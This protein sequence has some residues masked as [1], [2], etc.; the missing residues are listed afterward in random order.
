LVEPLKR[1]RVFGSA[2]VASDEVAA[3]D[4]AA[5]H[6]SSKL[7]TSG[8]FWQR[9]W[10]LLIALAGCIIV[11]TSL[12][13]IG[14]DGYY[15]E[16]SEKK[17]GKISKFCEFGREGIIRE[18]ANAFSSL[19]ICIPALI[20]LR[21]WNEMP[22]C[23]WFGRIDSSH[24][25]VAGTALLSSNS[26][27]SSYSSIDSPESESGNPWNCR[28]P[29]LAVF[30]LAALLVGL[31]SFAAHGTK[32]SLAGTMDSSTMVLW[33][34]IPI[35]WTA[36]RLIGFSRRVW[37][38]LWFAGATAIAV[39]MK[40]TKGVGVTEAYNIL[41]TIWL[42]LELVACRRFGA[43]SK[44]LGYGVAAFAIAYG[45]WLL[46]KRDMPLCMPESLLQLHAVWHIFCAAAVYAIWRHLIGSQL[47]R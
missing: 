29:E 18:P 4:A 11:V 45:A 20:I 27:P 36:R 21:R 28:S 1:R 47:Q 33:I 37:F 17:I 2:V 15:D 32:M 14:A 35:L 25:S 10:P 34:L 23:D 31:S 46:G 30:C 22:G 8:S 40:L 44:W 6:L 39:Y 5:T 26:L 41:I 38:T 16:K 7:E 43:P 24:G 3:D 12:M 9:R 19:V 13:A 42:L